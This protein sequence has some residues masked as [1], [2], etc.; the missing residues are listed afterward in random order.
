MKEHVEL[1]SEVGNP[2]R[3]QPNCTW[4]TGS[5]GEAPAI[6]ASGGDPDPD[7]S[8]EIAEEEQLE[9]DPIVELAPNKDFNWFLPNKTIYFLNS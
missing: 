4:S 6:E 7:D 5:P 9:D 1:A 8:H 3:S 2:I